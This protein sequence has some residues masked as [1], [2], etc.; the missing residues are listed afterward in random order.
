M[1]FLSH[2]NWKRNWKSFCS[3]LIAAFGLA[4]IWILFKYLVPDLPMASQ[5]TFALAELTVLAS[6][7][8]FICN[9]FYLIFGS[10]KLKFRWKLFTFFMVITGTC[11]GLWLM[12]STIE[13]EAISIV[14]FNIGLLSFS[15]AVINMIVIITAFIFSRNTNIFFKV[16]IFLLT[17]SGVIAAYSFLPLLLGYPFIQRMIFV[18][19][20]AVFLFAV[21]ALVIILFRVIFL[22]RRF[23]YCD[24][25]ETIPSNCSNVEEITDEINVI[26]ILD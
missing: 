16:F 24:N 1:E 23:M 12:G 17:L 11:A 14:S 26:L 10:E 2:S 20:I 18:A 6:G 15:A 9:I 8:N 25:K 21:I 19:A 4:V 13:A 5:I 3:L 7:V 22:D